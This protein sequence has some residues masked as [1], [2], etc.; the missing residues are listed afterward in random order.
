MK[1][2]LNRRDELALKEAIRHAKQLLG[3]K[4]ETPREVDPKFPAGAAGETEWQ[5]WRMF[6]AQM[7]QDI[8]SFAR[9]VS[10]FSDKR[11]R[12]ELLSIARM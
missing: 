5:L 3:I 1:P 11:K 12:M 4:W 10:W 6:L 2:A 7:T 9:L 8:L